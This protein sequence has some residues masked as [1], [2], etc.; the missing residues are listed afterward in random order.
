[1]SSDP[2]TTVRVPKAVSTYS[3]TTQDPDLRSQINTVLLREGHVAKIQETLLHALNASPTNWPTMIQ[4]H[5]LELLRSGQCTTFPA[6]MEKVLEDVKRDTEA[7]RVKEAAENGDAVAKSNSNGNNS[8]GA[9]EGKLA[10]PKNVVDEG[11]RITRECLEQV[12]EIVE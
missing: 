3:T 6:L 12:C 5:A 7:A 1:M 8:G 11:V 9:G 2:T 10:L 4:D